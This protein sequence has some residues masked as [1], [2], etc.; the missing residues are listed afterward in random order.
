MSASTANF[1]TAEH[2]HIL[3][4]LTCLEIEQAK[5]SRIFIHPK[6]VNTAA[7]LQI[8]LGTQ[9]VKHI[10]IAGMRKFIWI[11]KFKG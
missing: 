3:P 7:F 6:I 2:L 4:D 8:V 9:S 10:Q 1:R 11:S 5:R